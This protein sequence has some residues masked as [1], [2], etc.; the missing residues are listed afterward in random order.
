MSEERK[1]VLGLIQDGTI[2]VD[3]GVRLLEALQ[4]GA[5]APQA[6]PPPREATL[7]EKIRE[8]VGRVA[9]QDILDEIGKTVERVVSVVTDAV[10]PA[11][12][13]T[14]KGAAKREERIAAG[15]APVSTEGGIVGVSARGRLLVESTGGG[16][17]VAALPAEADAEASQA[18]APSD[19]ATATENGSDQAEASESTPEAS[20]W[21]SPGDDSPEASAWTAADAGEPEPTPA[22]DAT[23]TVRVEPLS[24]GHAWEWYA[25]RRGVDAIIAA[26][27]TAA[28]GRVPRLKVT[29]PPGLTEIAARTSGG[30][31]E[32][33]HLSSALDLRTSGG[34]ITVN[35]QEGKSVAARTSGG[36]ITVSGQPTRAELRTSGGSIR[37]AGQGRMESF[38]ART[39]GGSIRFS[40]LT[41]SFEAQTSGGSIRI[42]GAHLT[43]GTHQVRTAGGS[44]T[45]LLAAESS[46]QI[47]ARASAGGITVDLPGVSGSLEKPT[48]A[49]RRYRGTLG[50]GAATLDLRTAAGS[51]TIAALPDSSDV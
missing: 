51:I 12:G 13:W 38:Q 42:E 3:D 2:S 31:I 5:A 37:F 26:Y 19:P 8:G 23:S 11:T 36:R 20:A 46:V 32:T 18:A 16:L 47:D 45:A 21:V 43:S 50:D 15:W 41:E 14:A 4:P 1:R 25:L 49:N 28:G 24:E 27:P 7:E 40:G 34:S 30:S 17:I 9:S 29:V 39:S 22:D 35:E 48:P 10:G 6:A 44:I 33:D